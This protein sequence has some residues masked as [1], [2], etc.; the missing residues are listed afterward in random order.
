M[1]AWQA[2]DCF[3][4]VG[5]SVQRHWRW[6]LEQVDGGFQERGEG[7]AFQAFLAEETPRW[8][9]AERLH[10][11]SREGGKSPINLDR[12][13]RK[14]ETTQSYSRGSIRTSYS[15][16]ACFA[17]SFIP[18]IVFAAS[19]LYS[20]RHLLCGC[21]SNTAS[22]IVHIMRLRSVSQSTS[23]SGQMT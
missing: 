3:M 8:T 21:R 4:G 17:P 5:I 20:S 11:S 12:L 15:Q 2:M 23:L 6:R 16:S 7:S 1:A 9:R 13:Y 10:C 14:P 22:P 18:S 19:S